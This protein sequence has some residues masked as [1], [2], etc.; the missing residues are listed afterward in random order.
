MSYWTTSPPKIYFVIIDR[1]DVKIM[2]ALDLVFTDYNSAGFAIKEIHCDQEFESAKH[3]LERDYEPKR[4]VMRGAFASNQGVELFPTV[5][6]TLCA[7]QS[8][9]CYLVTAY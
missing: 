6:S 4:M 2:E 7:V 9:I 5:G 1:S 3:D 8:K